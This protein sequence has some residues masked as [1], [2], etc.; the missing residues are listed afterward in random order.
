M[1]GMSPRRSGMV[2]ADSTADVS[3]IGAVVGRA[4]G[5]FVLV[6]RAG[7]IQDD[8]EEKKTHFVCKFAI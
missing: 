8:C 7:A 1:K 6:G 5:C 4:V 2:G 3:A